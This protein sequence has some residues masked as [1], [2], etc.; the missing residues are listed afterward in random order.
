MN[1]DISGIIAAI[2]TGMPENLKSDLLSRCID[3]L[4]NTA[5]KIFNDQKFKT[6]IQKT[7]NVYKGKTIEK[8]NEESL[9]NDL[10]SMFE[11]D[12]Y[13]ELCKVQLK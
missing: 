6:I 7:F 5:L 2:C 13:V 3:I 10:N 12:E 9:A 1:I 8:Y 11:S 4:T